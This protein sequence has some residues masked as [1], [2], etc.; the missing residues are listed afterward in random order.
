V[1]E[2]HRPASRPKRPNA[3]PDIRIGCSGWQYKH[4][5]GDFYPADVPADR[6]LEYYARAFDTVEINSSFYRLPDSTTVHAWR[7]RVPTDFLFAWKG[8]RFL[9]HMRKLKD[10]V[11]PLH[12]LFQRAR[13]LKHKLGPVLYQLPPRWKRNRERF[14]GFLRSLPKGARHVVEFRDPSWYHDETFDAMQRHG[15]ALC[16]HD[17]PGS[18]PPRKVVGP[19]VYL[20]FHGADTRYRGGYSLNVLSSWANWLASVGDRDVY[21]YFNNDAEGHAHRDAIKLLALLKRKKEDS[22]ASPSR[23]HG[24]T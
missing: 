2:T 12:R 1:K 8:S 19:F 23:Q 15:V 7:T 16:L 22:T 21:V 3:G 6:W 13:L 10:P 4:W 9:T 11:D 14:D 17:M 5:R 20:R 18:M 24:E